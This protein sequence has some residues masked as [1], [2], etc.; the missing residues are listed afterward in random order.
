[1]KRLFLGGLLTILSATTCLS[2]P[3]FDTSAKRYSSSG[4]T[5]MNGPR[6]EAE[7]ISIQSGTLTLQ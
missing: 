6:L 7:L 4:P 2:A 1:M 5:A 3:T